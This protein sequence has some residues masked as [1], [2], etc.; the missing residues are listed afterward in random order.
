MQSLAY[1]CVCVSLSIIDHIVCKFKR[2]TSL[3]NDVARD[4][5]GCQDWKKISCNDG[6]CKVWCQYEFVHALAY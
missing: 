1:M 5:L 3:L 6:T 4:H 2:L